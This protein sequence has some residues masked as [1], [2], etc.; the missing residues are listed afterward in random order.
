MDIYQK[1][2]IILVIIL[3]SYILFRLFIQRIQ[4]KKEAVEGFTPSNSNVVSIQNNNTIPSGISNMSINYAKKPLNQLYI[5][6][7]YGGAYDG[8]DTSSDMLLYTLSLGYRYIVIHV[9]YDVVNG[10]NEPD[11][12]KTA[13]VGFA[14]VYPPVENI[15]KKT[16]ALSDVLQGIQQNAFSSTSPNPDDPFFLHIVPVYQSANGKDTPSTEATKGFNTQLNSQIE[17]SLALL[18]NSNRTSGPVNT[19]KTTLADLQG[20]FV[21]I[22]DTESSQGNMTQ[23]LKQ[24]IGLSVPLHTI[25]STKTMTSKT[26]EFKIVFPI[27]EKGSLLTSPPPYSELY[28]NYKINVSP[29]CPWLS[30]YLG[31]STIGTTNLGDY[32]QLFSK[33]GGSAF[34]AFTYPKK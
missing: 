18:K 27:D 15:A 11:A 6:A 12:T 28:Q 29:V 34:I 7:A 16:M 9:F 8:V 33:Q 26:D 31:T 22:M 19:T 23:N 10:G 24:M 5:K 4:L 17:Q 1:L 14:D 13:V 3:F 25:K 32:E 30:R 21:V 2:A 20:K